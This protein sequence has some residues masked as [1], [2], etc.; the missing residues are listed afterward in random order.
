[1]NWKEDSSTGS[2]NVGI[3]PE[4]DT[5]LTVYSEPVGAEVYL[6]MNYIGTTPL[7]D[8][9]IDTSEHLL[10]LK[11][12]GYQ[13]YSGYVQLY[14]GENKIINKKLDLITQKRGLEWL[15]GVGLLG[16]AVKVYLD[17]GKKK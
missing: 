11:L 7:P 3:S 4:G 5:L 9:A 17:R 2:L 15:I 6:D 1:M 12:E 13:D 14:S 8:Y 10:E 16:A